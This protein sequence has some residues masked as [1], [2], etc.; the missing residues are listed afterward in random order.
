MRVRDGRDQSGPVAAGRAIRAAGLLAVLAVG[1]CGAPTAP[2][3][4]GTWGGPDASIILGPEGGTLQYRCGSGSM[5]PGWTLSASG[6]LEGVGM[7]YDG[8][9]PLPPQGREPHPARYLGHLDGDRLTLTTVLTDQGLTLGP[10][11]LERNGALVAEAC[12]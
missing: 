6:V 7:H 12:P 5:D 1:A 9:G 10:F 4:V 3:I 8:G 11:E 2:E